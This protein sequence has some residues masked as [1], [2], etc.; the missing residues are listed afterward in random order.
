MARRARITAKSEEIRLTHFDIQD[1]DTSENLPGLDF[2]R[3]ITRADCADV[4][5]PC[6][7]IG[8]RHNLYLDETE[9]GNVYLN[10]PNTPV[11]EM[12]H[13]CVLD[14]A[15]K[16]PWSLRDTSQILG[17]TP[18]R[19]RQ[20]EIGVIE[21]LRSTDLA[22][23]KQEGARMPRQYTMTHLLLNPKCKLLMLKSI[24]GKLDIEHLHKYL[25]DIVP[26]TISLIRLKAFITAKIKQR[27]GAGN[28]TLRGEME[29]SDS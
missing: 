4:P 3:P 25:L 24:N 17:L 27:E 15:E 16:G 13:S 11:L 29:T 21:K 6:P 26:G 2:K 8:C 5:R 10:F 12:K 18:E 22:K 28:D 14:L 9:A 1:D 19:I 23:H 7:F 20:I